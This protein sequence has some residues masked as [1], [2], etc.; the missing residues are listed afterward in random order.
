MS[1]FKWM[2]NK[3]KLINIVSAL[4]DQFESTYHH[5]GPSCKKELMNYIET[6][7]NKSQSEIQEWEDYDTN[8][9]QIATVLIQNAC[10]SILASGAYRVGS[11][12]DPSTCGPRM[13]HVHNSS[14]KWAVKNNWVSE[15]EA[16]KIIQDI[17]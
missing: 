1:F 10:N 15:D 17:L 2:R 5:Y 6:R 16:E 9:P 14:V 7:V 13:L 11:F 12:L 8:Y 3:R 4:I